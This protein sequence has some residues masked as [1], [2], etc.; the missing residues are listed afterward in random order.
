[1]KGLAATAW[2]VATDEEFAKAAKDEYEQHRKPKV[3]M[4]ED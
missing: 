1:M 4:Y 2:R 3:S